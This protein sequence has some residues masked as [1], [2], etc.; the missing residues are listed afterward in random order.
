MEN[1]W[2]E[3]LTRYRRSVALA[4]SLSVAA[5]LA[6][7]AANAGQAQEKGQTQ[8]NNGRDLPLETLADYTP[9]ERFTPLASSAPC[10]SGG[11]QAQP[12]VLPPGYTQEIVAVENFPAN[13]T[14]DLWDMNTQNESGKEKGRYIYRTHEVGAGNGSDPTRDPNGSQVTVTDLQTGQTNVV[15]ERPDFERFDGIVWTPQET[16]LAGEETRSAQ[17]RDPQV[18]QATAG[19]VYEFFIDR[20]DPTRLDPTREEIAP[21]A[22]GTPGGV[23]ADGTTDTVQDGIRARPALGSKS[24]EGMRFDKEGFYYGI[25]EVNGGSMYRFEPDEPGDLSTGQLTALKTENG[26]T[27]EGTW[28]PLD[29]TAV[30]INADEEAKRVTANGYNRPEDVETTTSTGRDVNNG[31][32][33]VYFAETGQG[34]PSPTGTGNVFAIDTQQNERPFVYAYAGPEAGNVVT[35]E[36]QSPDNLA[37][38]HDGN[39]AIAEDPGGNFPAKQRGDDVFIAKPPKGGQHEPAETVQ[40][41]ASLTD[42]DAE[43]TGIYFSGQ[44]NEFT[45]PDGRTVKTTRETLFVNQQHAGP[46]QAPDKLIAITPVDDKANQGNGK[47]NGNAKK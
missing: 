43:P 10:I 21:D 34:F 12:F 29:R 6:M 18:P 14:R 31:Q 3:R 22:D 1:V 42:C 32:Q 25:S 13:R 9:F 20:D 27:G 2:R 35:T 40:R 39:L 16:I 44:E 4:A 46:G 41:F 15:A 23:L 30:Q 7:A 37:L 38:D 19:L 47:S 45:T 36:F 26:R 28:V 24:H 5:A 33:T 8:N 11:N 17:A